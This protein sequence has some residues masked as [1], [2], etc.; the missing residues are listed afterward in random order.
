MIKRFSQLSDASGTGEVFLAANVESLIL[1]VSNNFAGMSGISPKLVL[2]L[3]D[4]RQSL[5]EE[6]RASSQPHAR[7]A[8]AEKLVR[9]GIEDGNAALVNRILSDR[10][11]I[12][13]VNALVCDV[14]DPKGRV[15]YTPIE[16]SAMLGHVAVVKVLLQHG[17]ETNRSDR[18]SYCD[19]SETFD[20]GD[21]GALKCAF[22]EKDE[23]R[24]ANPLLVQVL[25]EAGAN[26]T[27]K[28]LLEFISKGDEEL[29]VFMIRARAHTVHQQWAGEGV[30]CSAVK[31]CSNGVAEEIVDI[32]LLVG[33]D[34]NLQLSETMR[35][36]RDFLF[37]VLDAAAESG[38]YAL[39]RKL[40]DN[41]ARITDYTLA[42]AIKSKDM[43]IVNHIFRNG[44]IVDSVGSLGYLA[45]CTPLSEAIRIRD[46]ELIQWLRDHGAFSQ[47]QDTRRFKAALDAAVEVG[48]ALMVKELLRVPTVAVA[49][50]HVHKRREEILGDQIASALG[51]GHIEICYALLKAGA[52]PSSGS[53]GTDCIL[54]AI[55]RE[56]PDLVRALLET[57]IRLDLDA[58]S[59]GHFEYH[60]TP[61]QLA[62][63]RGQASIVE[64]L[65]YAGD[66]ID[67]ARG[68]H[69]PPCGTDSPLT[70]AIQHRD[71]KLIKLLLNAGANVNNSSTRR[72]CKTALGVAVSI[73]DIGLV[74]ELLVR[75]A[76][77]DDT[78][79]LDQALLHSDDVVEFLLR[80]F[81]Q[82]YPQGKKGFGYST[83]ANAI[84]QGRVGLIK[85]LLDC[86][87]DVNGFGEEGD[88]AH[89]ALGIAIRHESAQQLRLT[90]ISLLLNAGADPNGIVAKSGT[91]RTALVEAVSSRNIAIVKLLLERGALLDWPA[92]RGVRRTPL[93]K[94]AEIGDISMVRY[95]L[96]Q[97]AD[98]NDAPAHLGGGTALQLAAIGGFFGLVE[99]LIANGADVNGPKANVYGRSAL[100]AAAEHGR[101]NIV[102][103]LL[104]AGATSVDLAGVR[105]GDAIVLAERNG[106]G[107]IADILRASNHGSDGAEASQKPCQRPWKCNVCPESE[108]KSYTKRSS[109]KRHV[110]AAHVAGDGEQYHCYDCT[111]PVHFRRKDSLYRHIASLHT[112]TAKVACRGCGSQCR[113]DALNAHLKAAG[114]E[115]CRRAYAI[116]KLPIR[117]DSVRV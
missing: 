82:R 33:A 12:L 19:G 48:N 45:P 57:G 70:I 116:A 92:T 20:P 79:A 93:Q 28:L 16:R 109:L 36:R 51:T 54:E 105:H 65:L 38:N 59:R 29:L 60:S 104:D 56:D 32:M 22:G 7:K 44:G 52:N 35:D 14:T 46:E 17:A 26:L 67:T 114:S 97:G 81:C 47:I 84:R 50:D 15:S 1:L 62:V 49:A 24:H 110:N 9:L 64:D 21:C 61:I 37:T 91:R 10:E 107:A 85:R 112:G 25:L 55:K 31:G 39:V 13:D 80:A 40:M 117:D 87:V 53:Y 68:K 73:R 88:G 63:E 89:N 42:M 71:A 100:E 96:D 69:A 106:H 66:N 108:T 75:G 3:L 101:F 111:P 30:F 90:I 94:A 6:Y 98:T 83:L 41:E 23:M 18:R 74:R 27:G 76:E 5:V 78:V 58:R 4:S 77:V 2:G 95:L 115:S 72:G 43:R 8:L 34:L 86:K 103:L 11:T 102:Q 99:I 113:R